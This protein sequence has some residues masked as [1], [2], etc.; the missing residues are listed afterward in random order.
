[1][2]ILFLF[3]LTLPS[4]LPAAVAASSAAAAATAAAAD[5]ASAPFPAPG[6]AATALASLDKHHAKLGLLPL[7]STIHPSTSHGL[8]FQ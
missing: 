8:F 7:D 3:A 4:A 1:M 5:P 2:N 6:R